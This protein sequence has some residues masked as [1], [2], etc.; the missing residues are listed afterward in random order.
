MKEKATKFY[1][2][3]AGFIEKFIKKG[4]YTIV[5]IIMLIILAVVFSAVCEY[6]IFRAWY[7]EFISKNRIMLVSLIYM[8]IGMHFIFNLDTMYE[9]IHKN[10]YKIAC[11]FLLFV[12]IFK[13]SGSSIVNFHNLIQQHSDNTRFHVLL[14]KARMIRT[15]EWATSTTYI[16][17][18]SKAENKFSYFNDVLR[19]TPTDM[20]TIGNSPVKDILML[21]RPLQI[22]F[23]LFGNDIGE[24]FYWYSRVTLMM[25]GAYELLLIL[26]KQ[27]KKFAL[28]GAIM[29]TFSAAVQWWYCMDTL[30][31][32]QILLVLEYKFFKADKKWI[33]YLCALGIIVGV[34]SYIFV[35][36][37]A[38]QVSF[39]YLF[40]ALEVFMLIDIFKEGYKLNLH[41]I[42]VAVCVLIC[43]ILL[44]VRWVNLSGS[45]IEA[46]GLTAYPGVR[47]E[48]GGGAR[49]LYAYFFNVFFAWEDYPNPCEESQML[50]FYPIPILLGL[51][52]VIRNKKNLRFWVPMLT[53]VAAMTV[54][55]KWGIPAWL[56]K[57]TLMSNVQAGRAT[58]P[59]GTACIYM[60]VY[61]MATIDKDDKWFKSKK[62][63]G[64]LAAFFTLYIMYQAKRHFAYPY[65][66]K[67]KILAGIEMFGVAIYLIF[68]MQDE[69]LKKLLMY[70]LIGIALITGLNVNPVIRTADILYE[71]PVAKKMQEIRS[72]NPNAIWVVNDNGWWINDYSVANGI[73]TLNSTNVYPNV[74]LFETL[75]GED[76]K[77]EDI[78]LIYNRY[79]HINFNIVDTKTEVV[80]LYPD[81]IILNV[82][83][84][85]LDKINVDYIISRE[86]LNDKGFKTKFEEVYN[87]DE[88]YIFKAK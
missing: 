66:D 44:L 28:M 6:T 85:D 9:F 88:M 71:K 60:L 20:F 51:Y 12:M 23:I 69:K 16:M 39:A 80:E 54:Y 3:I 49:N 5:K 10:R 36:Y 79:C 42:L 33:K 1:N 87:E 76:A 84:N 74:E 67:F 32:G 65:I 35:M 37:P 41:D 13:Y 59:L 7:P 18:Q 82:N 25:L 50:S 70:V 27:K 86:D 46:M 45:T 58:I 24:S 64:V 40:I 61:L 4:E 19:G 62:L 11:A 48:V 38:W 30:I 78:E 26:T 77:K 55:C 17:S 73:R 34:M 56:S 21:G 14:G 83:Y 8:F 72:E 43:V 57:I 47:L 63:T 81:N 2:N 68:N 22:G 15:D 29:I 52:Y 75:L 53:F 31:W